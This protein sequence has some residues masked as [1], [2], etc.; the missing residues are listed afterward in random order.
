MG[1]PPNRRP[2]APSH[3]ATRPAMVEGWLSQ[4]WP[5]RILRAFLGGTFVFAGMQKFLDPNFLHAGTP[6]F[7]GTQLTN[8]AQVSPIRG[9]LLALDHAPVLTGIAA[10]LT[11]T[12]VGLA[13]LLGIAPLAAAAAGMAISLVLFLSATWH[14]HPY[15]L[16]SDSVYA[17][18]WG[19]YLAGG[20]E[21]KARVARQRASRGSRREREAP[22]EALGRRE[23][24]RAVVVGAGS[25][26]LAVG[27]TFFAGT[28]TSAGAALSSGRSRKARGGS[29]GPGGKGAGSTP[30]V[31]GTPVA[32]LDS[33]PVGGAVSFQDAAQGPAV[34]CRLAQ[35]RV[36]A[37]SR[38]CTHAG[39]LVEYDAA[40]RI[41]VCPCHGAEFDPARGGLPIAGPAPTPLAPIRVTIDHA[42]GQV[43]A[44][45]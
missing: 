36:A 25:V 13:T 33:I 7:V 12:A 14:V 5:L 35:D 41:L 4:P 3:R 22:I 42:T 44:G 2:G 45:S 21:A 24:L 37:F 34:L 6:D 1:I 40:A 23:F 27:A 30:D 10:A 18:A 11:E 43:V 31:A 20:I 39:C 16:G 17:V 19:A 15:F 8:F 29:G 38:V 9:L 28:P 32:A 26:V